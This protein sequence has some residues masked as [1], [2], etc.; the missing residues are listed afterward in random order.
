MGRSSSPAGETP[1]PLHRPP[2]GQTGGGRAQGTSLVPARAERAG[3]LILGGWRKK[4]HFFLYECLETLF[5][6]LGATRKQIVAAKYFVH[7]IT[8]RLFTPDC[9]MMF[10]RS[11]G[12][13]DRPNHRLWWTRRA[14]RG[15]RVTNIHPLNGL[16]PQEASLALTGADAR[17][18]SRR[19]IPRS[20][21]TI[22]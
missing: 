22:A 19:P 8:G 12:L 16:R 3:Y 6:G 5:G 11:V 7:T 21:A 20:R 18:S 14:P 13:A 4:N 17:R 9:R 2:P 1:S 15:L 10:D